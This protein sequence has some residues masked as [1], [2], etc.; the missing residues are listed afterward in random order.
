MAPAPRIRSAIVFEAATPVK[1]G[2]TGPPLP[3]LKAL[4]GAA[5]SKKRRHRMQG[6]PGPLR[7]STPAVVL[8]SAGDGAT[9]GNSRR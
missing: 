9:E 4:T 5:A 7:R 3:R 6:T 2:P 8:Y 1:A